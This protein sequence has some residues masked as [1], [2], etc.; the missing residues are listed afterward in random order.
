MVNPEN[1]GL[2]GSRGWDKCSCNYRYRQ[3]L[4][5]HVLRCISTDFN[6]RGFHV[7]PSTGWRNDKRRIQNQQ[8]CPFPHT[9]DVPERNVDPFGRVQLGIMRWACCRKELGNK[10][11]AWANMHAIARLCISYPLNVLQIA[12]VTWLQRGQARIQELGTPVHPGKH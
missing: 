8:A 4:N 12:H 3:R 6:T 2:D 10:N 7:P 1:Q 11:P 9:L 5:V